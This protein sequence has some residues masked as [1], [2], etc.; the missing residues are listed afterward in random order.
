MS[1]PEERSRLPRRP[2]SSATACARSRARVHEPI[3]IVGMACRYPGGVQH[4]RTVGPGGEAHRSRSRSPRNRGWDLGALYDPDPDHPGT[5]YVREGG[6][7]YDAAEFDAEFFG[8]SPREAAA[9]DPQQRLLLET[10]WE[11][12]EH[13]GIEPI[14]LRGSQTG[15]FVGVMSPGLRTALAGARPRASR[16]TC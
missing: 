11:A 10:S 15:V 13:A 16:A 8:I 7:V 5:S 1:E 9:M 12:I 6:F 3:A 4:P 14:S 2:S